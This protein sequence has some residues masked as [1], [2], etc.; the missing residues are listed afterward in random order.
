MGFKENTR[1]KK[2]IMKYEIKSKPKLTLILKGIITIKVK[3]K[4]II[5]HI[6]PDK[7]GVYIRLSLS[8][9]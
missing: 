5:Y 2:M 7:I 9:F 6:F 4:Y 8:F 1:N 3:Y